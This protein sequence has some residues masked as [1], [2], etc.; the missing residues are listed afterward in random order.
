MA[1]NKKISGLGFNVF[2]I[3]GLLVILPFSVAQLTS[4]NVVSDE[5]YDSLINEVKNPSS[6]GSRDN[7]A[8][9][10]EDIGANMTSSYLSNSNNTYTTF[11]SNEEYNC[12]WLMKDLPVDPQVNS[13]RTYCDIFGAFSSKTSYQYNGQ[14]PAT[15]Y[16]SNDW[17]SMGKT[18]NWLNTFG[19]NNQYI[20]YSGKDFTFT[21]EENIFHNM[22]DSQDLAELQIIMVDHSTTWLDYSNIGGSSVIP[23]GVENLTFDYDI[24]FFYDVPYDQAHS[25]I[26]DSMPNS[27]KIKFNNFEFDGNNEY[28]KEIPYSP[29]NS[30][31]LGCVNGIEINFKFTP[32]EV[33]EFSEW[34][35]NNGGNK[36]LLSARVN[37]QNMDNPDFNSNGIG[38]MLLP[39]AGDGE[40]Q[41]Q[42]NAR[43]SNPTKINFYM[44]G[45]TFIL[46]AGLFWLAIASTPYYDPIR[47]T[48]KGSI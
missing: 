29:S 37:I 28:C 5:D 33:I 45:G 38:G 4:F 32:F 8:L 22:E 24:E 40:F 47:N 9:T 16:W 17:L 46:G 31:F 36:S 15:P 13:Y 6:I 44:K 3:V 20:G 11:N 35:N 34:F 26:T 1:G 2:A 25:Q 19:G 27:Q 42:V 23:N 14:L 10:W 43:Y 18:H 30:Y 39:F 48:F 7:Y 41:V 12:M 21:V